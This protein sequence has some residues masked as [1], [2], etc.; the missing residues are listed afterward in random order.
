MSDIDPAHIAQEWFDT[1]QL[2]TREL[3]DLLSESYDNLTWPMVVHRLREGLGMDIREA[4]RAYSTMDDLKAAHNATVELRLVEPVAPRKNRPQLEAEGHD[5][6]EAE[7][8]RIRGLKRWARLAF[9]SDQHRPYH[10]PYAVELA[11]RVVEDFDPDVMP[12]LSDWFDFKPYRRTTEGNAI[13]N[14]IWPEGLGQAV[15]EHG[16][17]MRE[18]KDAAPRAVFPSILGNHGFWLFRFL[19]ANARGVSD[20]ALVHFIEELIGQGL[21]WMGSDLDEIELA[22]AFMMLHGRYATKNLNT[23]VKNTWELYGN[24]CSVVA[25]HAHRDIAMTKRGKLY[26]IEGAISGCLCT[27]KAHYSRHQTMWTQGVVLAYYDPNG[28]G[29]NLHKVSFSPSG[30]DLVAHWANKEYRVKRGAEAARP[31][32]RLA[33]AA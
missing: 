25:G 13:F 29:V 12:G 22:P 1:G 27:L 15:D 4:R 18:V 23:T 8:A 10:D 20:Y 16:R 28:F 26:N 32:L 5:R 24:Q 33:D 11:L 30:G 3:H 17:W 6:W 9:V 31:A 21:I 19:E 2:T 14:T 7:R